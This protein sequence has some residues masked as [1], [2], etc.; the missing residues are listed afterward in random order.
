MQFNPFELIFFPNFHFKNNAPPKPKFFISL[1]NIN[2]NIVVVSLP[3]SQDFV[4]DSIKVEGCIEYPDRCISCFC[5]FKDSIICDNTGFKFSK[6][7]FVYA[8]GVDIY[9]IDKLRNTYPIKNIDYLVKGEISGDLKDKL[10]HC[11]KN[12]FDIKRKIKRIL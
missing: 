6:D 5:F 3:S 9:S 11:L 10:Y 7:T 8:N 4:P 2:G 1:S 12:S